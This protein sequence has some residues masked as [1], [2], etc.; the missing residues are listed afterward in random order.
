MKNGKYISFR[1]GHFNDAYARISKLVYEDVQGKDVFEVW[2]TTEKSWVEAYGR[3]A[4]TG[5]PYVFD[6]YHN[7]TGGWYHCNAYRPTESPDQVCVIFE[8]ITE[9][10]QTEEALRETNSYL[11]NLIDSANVPIIVW[12][13]S[14]KIT[15]FNR[16]FE[17][18]T[19]HFAKDVIGQP[20]EIL[21]PP[22]QKDHSMRLIHTT[23]D[24]VR[25]DTVEMDIQ[26]LSGINRKIIW[27]SSTIYSA[28]GL[29]PVATI[30]QGQDI[31]DQK[32][33]ERERRG[34]IRSDSTKPCPV[35][36]SE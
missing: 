4:V 20:L 5:N 25:W 10:R 16:E 12:D 7:P 35:I 13:T 33:L 9:Q 11:E 23:I 19:G 34:S 17:R 6:M 2:P 3:V 36:N 15:R 29:T 22:S 28:D 18:L 27:N 30:A 24:G 21:F 14:L 31:T 32:R 1:F 26:H 8:D